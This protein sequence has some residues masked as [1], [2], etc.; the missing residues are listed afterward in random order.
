MQ[1]IRE[2]KLEPAI[3]ATLEKMLEFWLFERFPLMTSEELRNMLNVLVPLE[4]TRAYQQFYAKG[5]AKG[6]I[7]GHFKGKADSL[8]QLQPRRFDIL[9][10][11]AEPRID[12]AS[13]EQLD[14]WLDDILDSESP[15]ALLGPAGKFS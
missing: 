10:P 7:E 14:A 11:W 3:Q 9:P 15:E 8:K 2:A 13:I 1:T 6:K 4:Q 5:E 12:A